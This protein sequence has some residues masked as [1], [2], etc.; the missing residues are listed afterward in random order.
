MSAT[1]DIVAK[2]W[3]LCDVLRDDGVTYSEYVTEL[4]YLLFLKMMAETGQERRI[5]EEY[6]WNT[7][8]RAAGLAQLTHY[9]HLLTALGD[10]EEKDADGKPKPAKDKLV[11][12]IFENA[13]TRLRKPASPPPSTTSTGS[14]RARKGWA[15]STRGSY[16]RT[17]RTRNP[18]PGSISPR[19]L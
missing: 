10:P 15:I 4:T 1:Q 14:M 19:V 13:Q 17:L 7:L 18:A 3:K 2:L 11:L 5:P 16:R 6:R 9:K 8:A 12:A